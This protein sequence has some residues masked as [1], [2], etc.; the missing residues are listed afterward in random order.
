MRA[1]WIWI[2]LAA[3]RAGGCAAN[4]EQKPLSAFAAAP[5]DGLARLAADIEAHG[6]I[7]TALGLCK[8]AAEEMP[9]ASAY[10]RLG[11]ACARRSDRRGDR[12]VPVGARA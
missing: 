6:E 10:V 5:S 2:G 8:Q 12:C 7:G 9:S 3:G 4:P 11:D 1:T